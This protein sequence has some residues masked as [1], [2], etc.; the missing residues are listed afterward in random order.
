MCCILLGNKQTN[1]LKHNKTLDDA[2]GKMPIFLIRSLL[3]SVTE[4]HLPWQ[5]LQVW[6]NSQYLS[7]HPW[8][9]VK[10]LAISKQ[11]YVI[12]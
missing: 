3:D 2:C 10:M 1:E 11:Y 8:T 6:F 12:I 9:N 5:E 7:L 4:K